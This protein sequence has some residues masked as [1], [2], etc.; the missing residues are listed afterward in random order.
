MNEKLKA[1]AL[2][3]LAA[4]RESLVARSYRSDRPRRP[5]RPGGPRPAAREHLA[6]CD[7]LSTQIQYLQWAVHKQTVEEESEI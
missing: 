2:A 5:S 1:R 4:L 6:A 7:V 3:A